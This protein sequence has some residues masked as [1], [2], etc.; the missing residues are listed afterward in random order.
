MK[1]SSINPKSFLIVKFLLTVSLF[2]N[3]T[4][5]LV[6]LLNVLKSQYNNFWIDRNLYFSLQIV[7]FI[8]SVIAFLLFILIRFHLHKKMQ[9]KY[10][11]KELIQIF[12][13]CIFVF[14]IIT[15]S[16]IVIF[17]DSYYSINKLAF[18][19]SLTIIE[20]AFGITSSILESFS[21]INEQA[22][23]NREWKL[24]PKDNLL[25]EEK[26]EIKSTQ[27]NKVKNPFLEGEDIDD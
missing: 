16:L 14:L 11:K 25:E 6:V 17:I 1:S 23:V 27:K 2:L 4:I 15:M 13:L 20:I 21:R 18:V 3:Y 9:Y 5:N 26:N 22:I 12:L 8:F 24:E 10:N 7:L 19:I